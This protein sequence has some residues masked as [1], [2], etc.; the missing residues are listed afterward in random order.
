VSAER[1]EYTVRA[2]MYRLLAAFP[3]QGPEFKAALDEA[4]ADPH[5]RDVVSALVGTAF[6]G[7]IKIAGDVPAAIELISREL[8]AAEDLDGLGDQ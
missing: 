3:N 5:L 2:A 8:R 4:M 6:G 1:D 7:Y